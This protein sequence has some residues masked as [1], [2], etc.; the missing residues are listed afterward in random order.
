MYAYN[1]PAHCMHLLHLDSYFNF[2]TCLVTF[3]PIQTSSHGKANEQE[4]EQ[5]SNIVT[6]NDTEFNSDDEFPPPLTKI[7]RERS[8]EI[9]RA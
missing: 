5:G 3:T 4:D 9:V 1:I 8:S 6:C 7:M 2:I